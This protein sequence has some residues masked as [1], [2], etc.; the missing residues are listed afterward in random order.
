MASSDGPHEDPTIDQRIGAL[1]PAREFEPDVARAR[2]RL[3]ERKRLAAR[4]AHRKRAIIAMGGAI[5]VILLAL[6]WPRAAAQRLWD[7]LVLGRVAV[8]ETS[9]PD[10]PEDLIAT[11]TMADRAPWEAEPVGDAAAAAR[12][13]GFQPALPP[14]GFFKSAPE[15]SVIRRVTLSTLPIRTAAIQRALSEAGVTDLDV[16]QEWEGATL[17]AEGGPVVV[18]RYEEDDVEVMQAPSLRLSTPPGFRFGHFMEIAFRVFGRS[19]DDART[20]GARLVEHPALVLHFPEHEEV[21]DVPLRS[22]TGVLVLNPDGADVICF[23]WNVSD[24]IFIVSAGQMN[25]G[26]AAKL[27]NAIDVADVRP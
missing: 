5:G 8:V 19:A 21:V 17:V 20:L 15:L 11:F 4:Q 22:G 25:P 14:D 18:A 1:E 2:G 9:R 10:V 7:R 12:L 16:P 27:A 13:A 3:E 24:R 6:P 26:Q 23:F